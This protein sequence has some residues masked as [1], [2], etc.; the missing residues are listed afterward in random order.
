M[1][2]TLQSLIVEFDRGVRTWCEIPGRVFAARYTTRLLVEQGV[3]DELVRGWAAAGADPIAARRLAWALTAR[4]DAR[5]GRR[6]LTRAARMGDLPALV[7]VANR[8]PRWRRRAASI[9]Y[10]RA[11]QRQRR[12]DEKAA[13]DGDPHAAYRLG[14]LCADDAG[15][16]DHELARAHR[17]AATYPGYDSLYDRSHRL[18]REAC[19]WLSRAAE[20]GLA[21][22]WLKL[23]QQ[24]FDERGKELARD[25]FVPGK[26]LAAQAL[27]FFTRADEMGLAEGSLYTGKALLLV[28]RRTNAAEAALRRSLERGCP[29]AVSCLAGVLLRRRPRDWAGAEQLYR[30]ATDRGLDEY[31]GLAECL[32]H[33]GD[34]DGAD[35][36]WQRAHQDDPADADRIARRRKAAEDSTARRAA[37]ATRRSGPPTS[38]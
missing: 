11:R 16:V 29:E 26:E 12:L 27:P 14:V 5:G 8:T 10:E 13:A 23:G 20:A 31:A 34:S 22:A 2:D 30:Q 32:E 25:W 9:R 21:E 19:E 33:L 35:R 3:W 37:A 24:D 1:A 36:A 28:H 6:A 15:T 38:R 7:A 18:H 4:G 17:T